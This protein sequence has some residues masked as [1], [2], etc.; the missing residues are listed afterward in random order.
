MAF[1]D[2]FY[3]LCCMKLAGIWEARLR[4][5]QHSVSLRRRA[6]SLPLETYSNFMWL[7][8]EEGRFEYRLG[9][10]KNSLSGECTVGDWILVPPGQPFY[11]VMLEPS[12]FHYARLDLESGDVEKASWGKNSLRDGAH[13]RA[14]YQALREA[15]PTEVGLR[16]K[17]HLIMDLLRTAAWE[18]ELAQ[19]IL[20]LDVTMGKVREQLETRCGEAISLAALARDVRLTPAAFS[21]RFKAA[22]G[23]GPQEFLLDR[24]CDKARGLLL[25][26]DLTIDAVARE[27]GFSNGFYFSRLWVKRHGVPPGRFRRE[28]RI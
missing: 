17:E 25:G 14:N 6:F 10:G 24:R 1:V 21:R 11:R 18:R 20:P 26:T 28:H 8:L 13:L 4:L 7:G 2:A 9:R 22:V 15:P 23:Q 12:A 3:T 27:C 5:Q 19:P 16:W